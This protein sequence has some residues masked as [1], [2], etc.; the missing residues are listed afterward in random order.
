MYNFQEN[1]RT[2]NRSLHFTSLTHSLTHSTSFHFSLSQLTYRS[3]TSYTRNRRTALRFRQVGRWEVIGEI[4]WLLGGEGLSTERVRLGQ[5]SFLGKFHKRNPFKRNF[6]KPQK[7]AQNYL[8][9]IRH[10]CKIQK[11]QIPPRISNFMGA[12]QQLVK[13]IKPIRQLL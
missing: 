3:R 2:K 4:R 10:F 9:R 1:Q 13:H 8:R 12:I 11:I 7:F 5:G 6:W